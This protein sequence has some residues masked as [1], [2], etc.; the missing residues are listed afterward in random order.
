MWV[1]SVDQ[2]DPLEEEMATDSSIWTGKLHG[3]K[4][5]VGNSP[6]GHKRWTGLGD[7]AHMHDMLRSVCGVKHPTIS[8]FQTQPFTDPGPLVLSLIEV[9]TF[10]SLPPL[11]VGKYISII[12]HTHTHTHIYICIKHR[13]C[14]VCCA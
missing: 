4:S 9:I 8:W 10:S 13:I 5:L 12:I 2:E 11:P 1:G 3:Q 7:W 6:W 14:A